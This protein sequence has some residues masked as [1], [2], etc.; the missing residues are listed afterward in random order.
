MGSVKRIGFLKNASIIFS[1]LLLAAV[2]VALSPW[3]AQN[4]NAQTITTTCADNGTDSATLNS[5]IAGSQAGDQ[6]VISGQCLLTA[7]ITLLGNRSYMGGSRTGTVLQQAKGANLS[8]LLAS[9]AY[10]NNS[11][12]TGLPFTI[13]QLTIDCNSSNNTAATSGLVIHSWQTQAEDLLVE[14]CRGSGILVTN[15]TPNGTTLTNT[16]V[17]GVISND[18]IE[19]SGKYGVY[20]QDSGNTVTDWHLTDNYIASSGQDAIHLENAAGWYIDGNHLYGDGGTA[21]YANRLFGTSITDN[22]IE[23]FG[24]A[25]GSTTWYGIDGTVQGDAASTIIANR[26]FMFSAE[27]AGTTYRYIAVTQVNYGGGYVTVTGN[28]IRGAGKTADTGFYYNAG[29]GVTLNVTSSGN[30]VASVGTTRTTGTGVTL[31]AGI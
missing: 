29:S 2:A 14:N 21:I 30:S 12:T 16:Q 4:A 6:I 15:T 27:K 7:P 24:G 8:Y 22:Y 23:D 10:V 5:A 20:V 3:S 25:G 18:F 26:V 9:D 11:S 28:D 1:L 19:N 13:H 31:S 17:N